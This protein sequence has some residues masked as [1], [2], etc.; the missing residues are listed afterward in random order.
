MEDLPERF[1]RFK[2]TWPWAIDRLA[3]TRVRDTPLVI[4][5]V[6]RPNE[7]DEGPPRIIIKECY[8]IPPESR[9]D[10]HIAWGLRRGDIRR[11]RT[12]ACAR[13][14]LAWEWG[15]GSLRDS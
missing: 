1:V 13:C 8:W 6:R 3:C 9:G 5:N 4:L 7:R 15:R 10:A 12:G 2:H 11:W 14:R